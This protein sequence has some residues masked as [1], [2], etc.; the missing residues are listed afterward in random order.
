MAG[1][2]Y[3]QNI[4]GLKKGDVH[5]LEVEVANLSAS[6]LSIG[7]S[8]EEIEL[9]ISQL[10]ASTLPYSAEETIKE[11]IDNVEIKQ[12]IAPNTYA[13]YALAL[14][15]LK[16]TYDSLTEAEKLRSVIRLADTVCASLFQ[17]NGRYSYSL[18]GSNAFYNVA[19]SLDTNQYFLITTGATGSTFSDNSSNPQES[20]LEL[21]IV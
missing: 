13:T 7:E 11:K 4:I 12:T 6:V 9:E 15:E 8:V 14:A 16:T 1:F 20:K 21:I 2:N 17:M 5:E 3:A 18:A 19:F 10:S